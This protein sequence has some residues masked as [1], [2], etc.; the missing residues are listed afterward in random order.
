MEYLAVVV[1][2]VDV[3]VAVAAIDVAGFE[4]AV[5][6]VVDGVEAAVAVAVVVDGFADVVVDFVAA[7]D[8]LR[9]SSR[10]ELKVV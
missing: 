5:A 7:V 9:G 1:G 6:V 8:Q 10:R 3:A 2:G 4:A